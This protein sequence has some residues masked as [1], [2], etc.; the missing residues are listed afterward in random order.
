MVE[1]TGMTPSPKSIAV[2]LGDRDE[3]LE[4][5]RR[6]LRTEC[7]LVDLQED[8]LR[9]AN[10]RSLRPYVGFI[11]ASTRLSDYRRQIEFVRQQWPTCPVQLI[12]GSWHRG[13]RRTNPID[14]SI[15]VAYWYQVWDQI[16]PRFRNHRMHRMRSRS[17][18]RTER[19]IAAIPS[20]GE[21]ISNTLSLMIVDSSARRS[22]WLDVS[23]WMRLQPIFIRSEDAFPRGDF[24]LIVL[25]DSVA[26]GELDEECDLST[27]AVPIQR[28]RR[29]RSSFPKATILK[30]DS[31]PEID[32]WNHFV[33]NGMDILLSAPFSCHGIAAAKS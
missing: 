28:L 7:H 30:V 25:D 15:D 17:N 26:S 20:V 16:L 27:S 11:G 18:K 21:S 31:L 8:W 12:L 19:L 9:D 3:E 32:R 6:Q 13:H 1:K 24:R 14:E 22:M 4:F 29:L 2:W 10:W 33:E 23:T 5:C